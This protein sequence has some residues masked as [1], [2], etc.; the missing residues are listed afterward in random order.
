[1]P[2]R[3]LGRRLRATNFSSCV[4]ASRRCSWLGKHHPCSCSL[5]PLGPSWGAPELAPRAPCD[6]PS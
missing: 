5:L 1:M 2:S 6:A 3:A 4:Q